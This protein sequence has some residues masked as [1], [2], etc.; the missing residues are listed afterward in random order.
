MIHIHMYTYAG[1]GIKKRLLR[2]NCFGNPRVWSLRSLAM[3]RSTVYYRYLS[4]TVY[5]VSS[6]S[7][8]A[9]NVRE[10]RERE[11]ARWS[12]LKSQTRFTLSQ[13]ILGVEE[14]NAWTFIP[15]EGDSFFIDFH[16]SNMWL[17]FSTHSPHA[18]VSSATKRYVSSEAAAASNNFKTLVLPVSKM[19]SSTT[20]LNFWGK[21]ER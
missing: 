9:T 15:I 17:F 13:S 21:T 20:P 11:R 19:K 12:R 4:T 16:P 2:S 7:V 8:S 18:C 10:R 3:P 5:T 1:V 14:L 6:A